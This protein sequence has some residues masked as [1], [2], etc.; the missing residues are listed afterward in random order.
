MH[1]RLGTLRTVSSVVGVLLLLPATASAEDQ[2][3][4][5]GPNE[6]ERNWPRYLVP[7]GTVTLANILNWGASRVLDTKHSHIGFDTVGRNFKQGFRFDADPFSVNFLAHP[8]QGSIYFSAAR[9]YGLTFWESLPYTL[10]GSLEWE[11]FGEDTPP[12]VN[13][14]IATTLS[15]I[16][17][18]EILYRLSNLV[19]D[20]SAHGLERGLRETVAGVLSPGNAY[21]R[22]TSGLMWTPGPPPRRLPLRLEAHAGP[23]FYLQNEPAQLG[24]NLGLELDLRYGRL[25]DLGS[26]LGPYELFTML[27][28][29]R[30]F[31]GTYGATVFTEGI[32][33][34]WKWSVGQVSPAPCPTCTSTLLGIVQTFEYQNLPNFDYGAVSLG[35]ADFWNFP[36]GEGRQ[37]LAGIRGAGVP[38]GAVSSLPGRAPRDYT[39]GAG[40]NAG[41]EAYLDMQRWGVFSLLNG[42]TFLSM[43]HGA[44]GDDFFGWLRVGYTLPVYDHIGLGG[45]AS[46]FF[47]GSHYDRFPDW[48]GHCEIYQGYLAFL[49]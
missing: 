14:L 22:L 34:G 18:G 12:S 16:A 20:N 47:R 3:R 11:F 26:T 15:G 38:I 8:Y 1:G 25:A 40:W 30:L 23:Q 17:L 32:V 35:L 10:L 42:Q 46:L 2:E 19:L 45:S 28:A 29:A 37:L 24:P 7:T 41:V 9:G 49:P 43:V 39:F 48:N 36:F 13:D 31:N 4:S 44:H 6:P 33:S 27:A 21:Y 5:A